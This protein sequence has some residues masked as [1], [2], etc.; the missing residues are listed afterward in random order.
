M[1]QKK[2]LFIILILFFGIFI[3]LSNKSYASSVS[4]LVDCDISF[5]DLKNE[6]IHLTEIYKP[7]DSQYNRFLIIFNDCNQY[8]IYWVS[9]DCNFTIVPESYSSLG[10]L[11]IVSGSAISCN[12]V[13][14]AH[15]LFINSYIGLLN[16]TDVVYDYDTSCLF[17]K[18]SNFDIYADNQLV[19]QKPLEMLGLIPVD[20]IRPTI[21]TT[22]I[23]RVLPIIVPIAVGILATLIV[24]PILIKKLKN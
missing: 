2:K 6:P 13:N 10:S 21:L 14:S 16:R 8:F 15:Y 23:K 19:F 1:L 12:G 22:E 18:Y 17:I 24:I 3:L 5:Y 4:E 7:I 20:T 11:K 9:D